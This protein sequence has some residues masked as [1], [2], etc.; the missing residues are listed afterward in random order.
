MSNY[1]VEKELVRAFY[2]EF[3]A[4]EPNDLSDVLSQYTSDDY[5]WRG[6]YPFDKLTSAKE[7]ATEFWQPLREALR[8]VQR[9]MDV[10]MAGSN[11][12]QSDAPDNND[13]W[14]VSMGHLLG[15]FD[16]PWLGI[17]PTRKMVMLRYCEFH[18]VADG[19]ITETA[20]YFDIPHLMAQAGLNP[21]PNQTA[22]QL[23]QP[24]PMT[25]N[26]L[27][28][29]EQDPE[30]GKKTLA[31]IDYMVG[32][33]KSWRGN[34]Q[35]EPLVEELRR[36][37]NEDMLWWGPTGIGATYTIERYAE[38]HAGPFRAGVKDRV[39][40]GHVCRMAEGEFGAFFGWPNLLLK[41]D[42][43]MG[44]PKSDKHGEMCVI[45]V[46]RRSGDK[47]SENWIFIDLLKFWKQQGI[48]V[49]A[50]ALGSKPTLA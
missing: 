31:A 34:D 49:L 2:D 9:R 14:V 13:I 29:D 47:L 46:Y 43:L 5:R 26:G 3:D 21:F 20:M 33:L 36:S 30:E 16:H 37:W 45:D 17:T 12:L 35:E 4:A 41:P 40:N 19:K 1:Q 32:E 24:G 25:H 6:Y 42:G 23:V 27:M 10:F 38:Q 18:R 15:L 11:S 48:D 7:V 28:F 8:P 22:A 39:F 50:D 44:Y